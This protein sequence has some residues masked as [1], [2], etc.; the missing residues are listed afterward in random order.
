VLGGMYPSRPRWEVF[1]MSFF[2]TVLAMAVY[3]AW[4]AY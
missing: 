4:E 1:S 2:G 3:D